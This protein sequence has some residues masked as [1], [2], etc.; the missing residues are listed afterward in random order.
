MGI[1][2]QETE[3]RFSGEGGFIAQILNCFWDWYWLGTLKNKIHSLVTC[4]LI[5]ICQNGWIMCNRLK[6]HKS[7]KPWSQLISLDVLDIKLLS[8]RLELFCLE[9]KCWLILLQK[10]IR[11]V[12][13]LQQNMGV[14]KGYSVLCFGL[15]CF[16]LLPGWTVLFDFFYFDHV[17]AACQKCWGFVD[18]YVPW[19]RRKLRE[20]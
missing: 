11:D 20:F 17:Y 18:F 3:R 9:R 8:C 12:I 14:G 10:M 4:R 1:E 2:M 15:F 19:E 13:L 6:L 5:H 7:E 16:M